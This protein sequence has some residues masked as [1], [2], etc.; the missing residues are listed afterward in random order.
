MQESKYVLGSNRPSQIF[1]CNLSI[2]F[3][4][5]TGAT[6]CFLLARFAGKEFATK[7]FPTRMTGFKKQLDE[8]SHR[9]PYFLLF[10]RLFPCSP[11][12]AINMCS[13]V[14]DVPIQTF[15]WTVLIGLMPYNYICVQTGALLS[16]LTSVNDI[17]TWTTGLQLSGI[18]LVA[19]L[20]G[21]IQGNKSNCFKPH[22]AGI[23]SF[24][25]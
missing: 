7:Y 6:C 18:A 23:K 5:A 25:T 2:S 9:L 20:P 12:W 22:N 13:G 19:L 21:I 15:W 3:N 17:L 16:T 10:L 1:P 4:V 11:N 8:N 24:R 14:L